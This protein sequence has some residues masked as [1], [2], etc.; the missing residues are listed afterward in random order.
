LSSP[1]CSSWGRRGRLGVHHETVVDLGAPAELLAAEV[2]LH[3]GRV[4]G[5]ELL[6]REVRPDHQQEVTVHHGV[7]AGGEAE[8]PGHA[9]V[10][11]IVVLDELLSAHGMHDGSVQLARE[12]DQLGMGPRAAR[13]CQDGDLL[14]RIEKLGQH[15]DLLG[16]R[17]HAGLGRGEMQARVIR[18]GV[19][20]GDVSGQGDDRH[21]APR[22]RRL[23]GDLQD[24]GHVLG[25]GHQLAIVAALREEVLRAGLL[26][27]SAADLVAGDLRGDGEDGHPAAVTVVEA[28]DQVQIAGTTAAC[29]DGQASGEMRVCA[30]G[31]GRRLLVPHV[32]PPHTLLP[33]NRIGDSVQGVA[34]YAVDPLDSLGDQSVDEEIRD[35][36]GHGTSRSFFS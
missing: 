8:Q 34:G 27:V 13:T 1:F 11:R 22:E 19:A 9:H 14:R 7:I 23:D 35:R 15:E 4:R 24:P 29:A 6:V 2:D 26:E 28:V 20:Q 33:A 31:E 25:L 18:E 16:R 32:N 21:A 12:L 17:R 10:E 30:R 3:D 36:L 5:K